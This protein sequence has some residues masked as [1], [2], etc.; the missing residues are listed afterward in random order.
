MLV[1]GFLAGWHFVLRDAAARAC[2]FGAVSRASFLHFS[3]PFPLSLVCC[4]RSSLRL[5][6]RCPLLLYPWSLI[7]PL[8][9]GEPGAAAEYPPVASRSRAP[10]PEAG[11]Y[12]GAAVR[13]R[14]ASASLSWQCTDPALQ[15]LKKRAPP[16]PHPE[17]VL[18]KLLGRRVTP[19]APTASRDPSVRLVP[20][21]PRCPLTP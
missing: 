5:F 3:P 10:P 13:K 11:A 14:A 8:G 7:F 17:K 12:M 16:R 4:L 19:L 18:G 20:V 15:A 9:R 1:L 6:L 2:L 21:G